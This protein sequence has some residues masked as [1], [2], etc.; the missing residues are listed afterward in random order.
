MNIIDSHLHLFPQEDTYGSTMALSVGHENNIPYLRSLF[1]ELNIKKA[2]V[3]GNRSL[4]PQY[5]QYPSD[6]FSYCIGL[7]SQVMETGLTQRK[8]QLIEENLQKPSCCGIK[9]Y[10]GYV[11]YWLTDPLY[12]PI[13]QLA[14]DY[15]KPIAVHMGLTAHPRAS[16]KYSHPLVLDE[17]ASQYRKVK[18]ILCHFG[19]P[20]LTDTVAVLG[21]NPNVSADLSGLIDGKLD[22]DRYYQDYHGYISMLK[23]WLAYL[24]CWDRILFGTD[25]PLVNYGEY[26][27]FICRLIPESRWENVFYQN[28]KEIYKLDCQ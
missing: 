12:Q 26:I 17:V 10:P 7:D 6:L 24:E 15:H 16:L 11:K 3:M 23:H 5:H 19:N 18:F 8:L 2:V 4:D 1:G 28:A 22:V 9:L 27:E 21:K 13:Y 25:F 20:Y 14:E